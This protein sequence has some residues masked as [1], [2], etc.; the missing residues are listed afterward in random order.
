MS[1][2]SLIGH[3]IE[4]R[5]LIKSELG[6]GGMGTVYLAADKRQA[7]RDVALKL[8]RH[9]LCQDSK[10]RRRFVKES[11][12]F[13]YLSHPHIVKVEHFGQTAE[14]QLY[15]A[16]EY[17][18]S[19]SLQD[20]RE[21]TLPY[22]LIVNLMVQLLEALTLSH[23]RGIVHRDLK[24][25]NVL[26]SPLANK[27]IFVKLVDFGIASLPAF[28]E[29]GEEF[30]RTVLGTPYY[31]APEQSRGITSQIGPGTDIYSIGVILY[32]LLSGRVPYK[33]N[34][35]IETILMHINDPIPALTFREGMK[36]PKQVEDI[37]RKAMEKKTWDRYVGAS[38]LS[39]ALQETVYDKSEPISHILD[40]INMRMAA[41][42]AGAV[43]GADTSQHH[44]ATLNSVTGLSQ[45]IQF[46]E[47]IQ[48]H[49]REL[50]KIPNAEPSD[51][52]GSGQASA[53]RVRNVDSG[54]YSSFDSV[55]STSYSSA[56][57]YS[58]YSSH[59]SRLQSDSHSSLKATLSAEGDIVGRDIE[60]GIISESCLASIEGR[61][62]VVVVEGEWG[63]GKTLISHSGVSVFA[64][65]HLVRVNSAMLS[66]DDSLMAFRAMLEDAFESK[67]VDSKSLCDYLLFRFKNL[68]FASTTDCETATRVLRGKLQEGEKLD[69][70]VLIQ[71]I[72]AV[73]DEMPQVLIVDDLHF[74]DEVTTAFVEAF[75]AAC[76]SR[77]MRCL[78]I[79]TIN[80]REVFPNS[81]LAN[82]LKKLS[83]FE[84]AC[85]KRVRL[86]PLSDKQMF[87]ILN[88]FYHLEPLLS[89]AFIRH[90]A[91]NPL[92]AR[93]AVRLHVEERLL[94][95]DDSGMYG[96]HERVVPKRDVPIL[97]RELLADYIVRVK[98][99]LQPNF[100][101]G[102]LD[103]I[104][105]RLAILGIEIEDELLELFFER[106]GKQQLLDQLDDVIEALIGV[107]F[108]AEKL[109]RNSKT[110]LSFDSLATQVAVLSEY[111]QRK[112]R[113]LH[114]LA[115]EVKEEY[116][117]IKDRIVSLDMIDHYRAIGEK[118][119][120]ELYLYQAMLRSVE[121]D[122]KQSVYHYGML[123][124]AN[125]SEKFIAI[126]DTDVKKEELFHP[127]DWPKVIQELGSA[128][129]YM[130][131]SY[132]ADQLAD[133]LVYCAQR[134]QA[135][136]LQARAYGLMAL[137]FLLR[138]EFDN[139]QVNIDKA[140][141]LGNQHGATSQEF[142]ELAMIQMGLYVYTGSFEDLRTYVTKH[143][144]SSDS[145][146]PEKVRVPIEALNIF[147]AFCTFFE[148]VAK[149]LEFDFQEG[150]KLI[151][152][153]KSAFLLNKMHLFARLVDV[154]TKLCQIWLN[155]QDS[156]MRDSEAMDEFSSKSAMSGNV[157]ILYGYYL[158][159]QGQ[160]EDALRFL[161]KVESQFKAQLPDSLTNSG[162]AISVHIRGL[163][164]M[165]QINFVAAL[166]YFSESFK[167]SLRKNKYTLAC[168]MLS[169]AQLALI[170]ND[171]RR[172]ALYIQSA[173]KLLRQ[174]SHDFILLEST[175]IIW[176]LKTEGCSDKLLE[177]IDKFFTRPN[178]QL[179]LPHSISLYAL[180]AAT[181]SKDM[182]R[183]QRY[184]GEFTKSSTSL[185]DAKFFNALFPD[186]M[187]QVLEFIDKSEQRELS[188]V[189]MR[190]G[191]AKL[192]ERWRLNAIDDK[193]DVN[194]DLTIFDSSIE[195]MV[196]AGVDS[197]LDA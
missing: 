70:R 19:V 155:L 110:A 84:G 43:H 190:A 18:P 41:R 174:C 77:R 2:R 86:S 1:K 161:S 27:S 138:E 73:S 78:L 32:E 141:K 140:L 67:D 139:V 128:M 88:E 87:K 22:H 89:H 26:L 112:L 66:K 10:M 144:A 151:S 123:L 142:T 51:L 193:S 130:G 100:D 122:D 64:E 108:L 181:L 29:G 62:S 47:S 40:E 48:L 192:I 175:K 135:P 154:M 188:V 182:V 114:K 36:A 118:D 45:Q 63:L 134:Y 20:L 157:E 44:T 37:V 136:I 9:E 7:G 3:E 17:I 13:A 176:L 189:A 172:T 93:E 75:A 146:F 74:G 38:E 31:M 34:V 46:P 52:H 127:I 57:S 179:S 82:S 68:R 105:L 98:K 183:L 131:K 59:I 169:A 85:L 143:R 163:I 120:A 53:R 39:K 25:A 184:Y 168:N 111:S 191:I 156:G 95:M 102:V 90:L 92:F 5:Y 158:A 195:C 15:M 159:L 187:K 101:S 49:S 167:L 97:I 160:A 30:T 104:I 173:E 178:A 162:L 12:V 83:R 14:G 24:P 42:A 21:L 177:I 106:E 133:K 8:I 76:T 91:G 125:F 65:K 35:D 113:P 107:N 117:T 126:G 129:F 147:D 150:Y 28:A 124:Y 166:Q 196:Q 170:S 94:K 60:L 109:S 171:H 96:L 61:G 58:G 72:T 6:R 194:L 186:A 56:P 165:L 149:I 50:A 79:V 137:F 153:V 99:H 115:A 145:I 119:K 121:E 185:L 81:S 4:G 16:M 69:M 80:L 55:T 103:D 11:K 148:G 116:Y 197:E 23:L 132:E 71:L 164:A 180:Y 33:G 152:S 54:A